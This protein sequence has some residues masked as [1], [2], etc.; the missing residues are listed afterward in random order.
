MQFPFVMVPGIGGSG[1]DHWQSRWEASQPGTIRIAPKSWD[2][3]DLDDWI[4]ALENAVGRSPKPPVVICH[5]LGCLLFAH[6]RAASSL[7]EG[8]GRADPDG[9][10][11]RPPRPSDQGPAGTGSS[12][13]E[14]KT[15][16]GGVRGTS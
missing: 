13:A 7:T 5:S 12:A 3:P 9:S 15:G 6:W 14:G 16:G 2:V 4:S 10:A 1:P 8:R 11:G